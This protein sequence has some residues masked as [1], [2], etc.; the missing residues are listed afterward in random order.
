MPCKGIY[1]D[2][3]KLPA[4]NMTIG[5]AEMFIERYKNYKK[6]YETCNGGDDKCKT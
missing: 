4:D 3:K 5:D 6:F 1:V 2:L